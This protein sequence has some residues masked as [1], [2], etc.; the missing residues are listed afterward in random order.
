M[1]AAEALAACLR[2]PS[3][4]TTPAVSLDPEVCRHIREQ[5][6][7]PLVYR[8]LREARRLEVQPA[9]V[10]DELAR[11]AREEAMIE[12]F[13][14]QEVE[15]V[16]DALADAG[17]KALVFKGTALAYTCYP[18]P[19]LRPRLDTDLF[20]RRE[21]AAL[22][23]SVL[24]GLGCSR[25]LRTSGEHVTHQFTYIS[26]RHGLQLAFDLHWKI[27]DPQVFADLFSFEELDRDSRA[28][29]FLGRSARVPGVAHSLVIACAHR[30]A[31]HYDRE[32]FIDFCDIDRLARSL[33][34]RGWA[35]VVTLAQVKQLRRVTLRG[36]TLASDRLGTPVPA[37]VLEELAGSGEAEPTAAFLTAGLRKVDVLRADLRE[38][39]WSD[40]LKLIREH[41]F[42]SPAF[43][44]R[45]YGK[46]H[47]AWLPALYLLRIAR[48]AGRWF[49]PLP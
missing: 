21:D 15:R 13:R 17:V 2:S 8:A 3:S 28:V 22:A 42:P 25:T 43:V 35:H 16:L 14:R 40:R 27:S 6:A 30:V 41:V 12:P 4:S 39:G 46:T 47:V 32:V 37:Q 5:G 33:D 45:S 23:A 36:L 18:D 26:G 48:G 44:L 19:A 38:L 7:G 34:D 29:P 9:P 31:H 1:A 11:L 10:R 20:I 49:R 24:E